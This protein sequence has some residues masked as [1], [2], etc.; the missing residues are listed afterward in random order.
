LL[1]EL[2]ATAAPLTG[3]L[4]IVVS[5]EKNTKEIKIRH[6]GTRLVKDGQDQ[7]GLSLANLKHLG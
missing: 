5:Q 1:K 6:K 2:P 7:H 3:N 4:K